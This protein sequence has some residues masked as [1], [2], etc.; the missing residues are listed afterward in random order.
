MF[1]VKH[2]NLVPSGPLETCWRICHGFFSF[3]LSEVG[4]YLESETTETEHDKENTKMTRKSV[5]QHKRNWNFL[6]LFGVYTR[7]QLSLTE[8]LTSFLLV[9]SRNACSLSQITRDLLWRRYLRFCA[10]FGQKWHFF[11]DASSST[12]VRNGF[13][14]TS[15]VSRNPFVLPTFRIQDK[16]ESSISSSL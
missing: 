1:W 16:K 8:R 10:T 3:E 15:K 9:F 2:A 12:E 13:H 11:Q 14:D 7:T 4:F 6:T 5:Q